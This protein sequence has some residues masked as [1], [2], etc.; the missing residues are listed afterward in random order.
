MM[1]DVVGIGVSSGYIVEL[2]NLNLSFCTGG[3]WTKNEV[4]AFHRELL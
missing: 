4:R 1:R 2:N 3:F